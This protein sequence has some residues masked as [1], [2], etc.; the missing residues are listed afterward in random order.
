M[1][2]AQDPG[3]GT[4]LALSGGGFRATLFHLGSLLRLNELGWLAKLDTVSSV[5][6]GSIVGAYLGLRWNALEFTDGRARNLGE[7]VIEPIRELCRHEVDLLPSLLNIVSNIWGSRTRFLRTA[8]ARLLFSDATLADLP[9]QGQG[10]R[11]IMT[12]SNLQ[13]GSLVTFERESV[14]DPRLGRYPNPSTSLAQVVAVSS[15]YPP[16]LSPVRLRMDPQRW[17]PLPESD[18]A[19]ELPLKSRLVLT[20]GGM[21]DPLALQPIWRD[22][23]T[24]LVSD[25]SHTR[26]VWRNASAQ[27]LRQ[28]NRT[29]LMQTFANS[30]ARREVI[31]EAFKPFEGVRI[32][33]G[34]YW[35]NDGSIDGFGLDDAL[36]ADSAET[37]ALAEVRTRLNRFDDDEQVALINW[38]YAMCD[39][40]MRSSLGLPNEPASRLPVAP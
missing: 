22:H 10:P 37:R 31:K 28:L 29:T 9:S 17:Q 1:H 7:A 12:G 40:A 30:A 25:A 33:R 34:A 6:G 15:A 16:F 3:L 36:L 14:S 20:D 23:Y 27:W 19:E 13:T 8:Y 38:G 32:R 24:L 4:A 11:F 18:L 5:S 35:S 2:S 26:E 21:H 39:A